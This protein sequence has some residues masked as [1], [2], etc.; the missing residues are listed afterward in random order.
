[1]YHRLP[2]VSATVPCTMIIN[3]T[4]IAWVQEDIQAV[5]CWGW[6][7]E[8]TQ[9]GF[10]RRVTADP[11]TKLIETLWG[12][13]HFLLGSWIPLTNTALG[14]LYLVTVILQ[15]RFIR[16][17][18][19][20]WKVC[21]E[22]IKRARKMA[23]RVGYTESWRRKYVI[24]LFQSF[25]LTFQVVRLDSTGSNCFKGFKININ[26]TKVLLGVV[27][28][29]VQETVKYPCAVYRKR[30]EQNAI[31]Y[32]VYKGWVHKQYSGIKGK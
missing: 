19:G 1:M 4:I 10:S 14:P 30:V 20:G 11:P 17:L 3:H 15:I 2:A 25:D 5:T 22:A 9:W 24:W 26:Q 23:K 27:A 8:W 6:V 18:T 28:G 21:D 16:Q 31:Q 29:H 32:Q 12:V 7:A 13:R